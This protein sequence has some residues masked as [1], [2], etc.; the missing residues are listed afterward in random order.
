[1]LTFGLIAGIIALI[2]GVILLVKP[3]LIIKANHSTR[4]VVVTT[5]I[6]A[7]RYHRLVGII[8]LLVS[9]VLFYMRIYL[10]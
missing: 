8:L 9:L 3:E 4:K 1:M 6:Y 5:D 2:S 10:L 7:I